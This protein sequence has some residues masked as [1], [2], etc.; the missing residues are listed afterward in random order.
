MPTENVELETGNLFI[1]TKEDEE[2]K[3][4]KAIDINFEEIEQEEKTFTGQGTVT[5]DVKLTR[6]IKKMLGM[7]RITRKRF[8]FTSCHI[9][10]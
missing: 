4:L 2:P 5:F 8:K 10:V 3:E 9:Y 7:E 6:R 1:Q